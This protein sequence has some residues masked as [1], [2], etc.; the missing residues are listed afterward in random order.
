MIT[1]LSPL[2]PIDPARIAS[3]FG[4]MHVQ[5]FN[6]RILEK[7]GNRLL[8]V[9]SLDYIGADQHIFRIEGSNR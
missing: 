3:G 5:E 2:R 7:S 4:E 6:G 8:C 1:A 9:I